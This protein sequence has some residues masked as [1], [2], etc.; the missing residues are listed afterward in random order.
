M[1]TRLC[2]SMVR[3]IRFFILLILLSLVTVL[4]FSSLSY[5]FSERRPIVACQEARFYPSEAQKYYTHPE[6]LV[7][8]PWR[9]PH[10]VYAIFAIPPGYRTDDAFTLSIPG[11]RTYCGNFRNRG[12]IKLGDNQPQHHIIIQG[13]LNTRVALKLIA[14]GKLNELRD[15]EHWSLGYVRR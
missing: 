1:K 15:P 14:Q 5:Y 11:T 7:I 6:K 13:F 3:K 9:G 10:N 8:R 2:F 4:G 12:I